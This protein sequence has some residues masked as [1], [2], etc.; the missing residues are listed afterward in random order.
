MSK[1]TRYRSLKALKADIKPNT[2]APAK[3]KKAHSEF[4][5]FIN[6]LQRGYLKKRKI[7]TSYG[8]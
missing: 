1:L 3:V 7:K 2:V 5:A 8:K 4:E 6:L